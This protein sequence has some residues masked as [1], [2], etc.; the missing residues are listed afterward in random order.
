MITLTNEIVLNIPAAVIGLIPL[1][2]ARGIMAIRIIA[3]PTHPKKCKFTKFQN[4]L[5][6]YAY[7]S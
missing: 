1:D 2:I 3:C 5:V 6:L 4:E 7:D